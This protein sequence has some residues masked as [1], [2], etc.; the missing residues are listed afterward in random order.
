[1]SSV[2]EPVRFDRDVSVRT[3]LRPLQGFLN[4]PAVTEIAIVRPK[5]LYTREH[6]QWFLHECQLLSL[7]HLQALTN[8]LTVYNGLAASPLVSVLLPDGERGQIVQPPATLDGVIAINIRKHMQV[9]KTLDE[10]DADGAFEQS[11]TT[12]HAY[13]TDGLTQ[14]QRRLKALL[15]AGQIRQF[16]ATAVKGR[17]NIVIS[18]ATGSGKTTFARSL[19]E[20]V[21]TDERLITIEDV[22]EL[23][24]AGHHNV[25]HMMYGGMRG[26]I[27]ATECIA[28]CMRLSPDRIFLAELR[29]SEAW[30][31]LTALNTGHPGSITTTHANSAL[32]AFNRLA[33]LI[34]QSPTG[35]QLDLASIEQF[36]QHTI[37]VVVHF[38]RFQLREIHFTPTPL[39]NQT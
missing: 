9:T 39:R 4:C 27:S 32:D 16:L 31:Y 29:G 20:E 22:H 21:A 11:S 37:D 36:L 3:F 13:G 7:E 5:Q 8:A 33:M 34:K 35:G 2:L 19:I 26:R 25:V 30:E 24:L 14:Q 28:A 23:Q 15:Q 10:L 12:Q 38:E 6:G 1:M 18:G 17:C